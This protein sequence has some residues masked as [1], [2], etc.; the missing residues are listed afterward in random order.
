LALQFSYS[1]AA[2]K[3]T[4]PSGTLQQATSL[5]GPW[6]AITNTSPFTFTPSAAQMFFRVKAN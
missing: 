3:L 6:S 4:W 5:T 2:L 1:A